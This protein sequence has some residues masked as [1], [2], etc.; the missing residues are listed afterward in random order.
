MAASNGDVSLTA[1]TIPGP[2]HRAPTNGNRQLAVP[3]QRTRFPQ[4]E[5]WSIEDTGPGSS[6]DN[7]ELPSRLRPGGVR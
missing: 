4:F 6:R 2:D 7:W 1:E 3:E 5:L